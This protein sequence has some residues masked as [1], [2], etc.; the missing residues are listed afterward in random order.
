MSAPYSSSRYSGR[1]GF[2]FLIWMV[3]CAVISASG[4]VAYA[5]CKYEQVAIK[6]DIAELRRSIAACHMSANQYRAKTNEQ[7]NCWA[8]RDRLSQDGSE[9]RDIARSQI[10]SARR[11]NS[12]Q[13]ALRLRP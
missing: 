4:G 10:E 6:T 5:L 8:M 9:L 3:V 13:L 2:G 11:E 7:M 12:S 1:I